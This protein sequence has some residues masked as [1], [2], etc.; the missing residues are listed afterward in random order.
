MIYKNIFQ[1]DTMEKNMLAFISIFLFLAILTSTA[2]LEYAN[3]IL[4]ELLTM[5]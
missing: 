2:I 4:K 3:T 5:W 1:G